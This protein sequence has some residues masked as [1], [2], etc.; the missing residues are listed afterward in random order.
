MF[1]RLSTTVTATDKLPLNTNSQIWWSKALHTNLLSLPLDASNHGL[2]SGKFVPP[3]P[4][5]PFLESENAVFND[6]VTTCDLCK[7]AGW[8][9]KNAFYF[10]GNLLRL[11]KS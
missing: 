7:W 6:G 1:S 10:E 5:P 8:K 2:F 11:I 4:R 3:P 9:E